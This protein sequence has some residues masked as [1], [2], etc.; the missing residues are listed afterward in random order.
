MVQKSWKQAKPYPLNCASRPNPPLNSDP[1]CIVV[2]SLSSFSFLGSAQR[3]GAGGAG[4]LPSLGVPMILDQFIQAFQTRFP[5]NAI[6]LNDT[7]SIAT[8]SGCCPELGNIEVQDEITELIVFVGDITHGHFDCYE[9]S[10]TQ[11]DR[12]KIVVSNV[13]DFFEEVFAGKIEFW[14]SNKMGGG[15]RPVGTGPQPSITWCGIHPSH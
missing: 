5:N 15:W 2:R 1:A 13:L 11:A 7:N 8:I 10:L 12:D 14:G 4:Y 9:E 6:V 3:L